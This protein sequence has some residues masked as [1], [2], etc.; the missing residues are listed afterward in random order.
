MRT[1]LIIGLIGSQQ[2]HPAPP[3][4]WLFTP[5]P[6]G[7]LSY[8]NSRQNFRGGI[9]GG[10]SVKICPRRLSDR[11]LRRAERG[12]VDG[13]AVDLDGWGGLDIG[14]CVAC[15]GAHPVGVRF[16]VMHPAR[17]SIQRR[18]PGRQAASSGRPALGGCWVVASRDSAARS[19]SRHLSQS[20]LH[21]RRRIGGPRRVPVGRTHRRG[22]KSSDTDDHT[23]GWRAQ[24]VSASPNMISNC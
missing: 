17:R 18:V 9:A 14:E 21:T 1:L 12:E 7:H 11:L 3:T 13:A 6:P 10:Q 15:A 19:T 2:Q 5:P 8:P 23:S 16:A 20:P 24:V 4:T 22:T